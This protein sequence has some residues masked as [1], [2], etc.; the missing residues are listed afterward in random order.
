MQTATKHTWNI[1]MNDCNDKDVLCPLILTGELYL[2]LYPEF[3]I[4]N[5]FT[6][7]Y[8]QLSINE[9]V[10]Y[11]GSWYSDKYNAKLSNSYFLYESAKEIT[12]AKALMVLVD[13]PWQVLNTVFPERIKEIKSY[14]TERA[15]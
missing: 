14:A 1:S 10:H 12:K 9:H 5:Y 8:K 13:D 7:P 6:M 15:R 4:S 11:A 2:V 3:G